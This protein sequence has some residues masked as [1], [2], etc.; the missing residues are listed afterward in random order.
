MASK[1]TQSKQCGLVRVNEMLG[2]WKGPML[3][4]GF[5]V[6]YW[7]HHDH[8]RSKL[9]EWLSDVIPQMKDATESWTLNSVVLQVASLC[10]TLNMR[11]FCVQARLAA[12]LAA[13][14]SAVLAQVFTELDRAR[15]TYQLP[16]PCP[17][18]LSPAE[19]STSYGCQLAEAYLD[20]MEPPAG[21]IEAA[22]ANLDMLASSWDSAEQVRI[23]SCRLKLT[24][25]CEV[26]VAL[27]QWNGE[28][29]SE[30]SEETEATTM[31]EHALK[32][33]NVSVVPPIPILWDPAAEDTGAAPDTVP[34][35]AP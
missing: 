35:Y 19:I 31:L 9:L 28:L 24:A 1:A 32:G 16:Y 13:R 17:Q 33:G 22:I 12:K 6:W 21:R 4:R 10:F 20:S 34:A 7:S 27:D 8:K 5:E 30:H 25:R 29:P 3:A 23:A 26:H 14:D 11:I 18:S 15:A 2:R